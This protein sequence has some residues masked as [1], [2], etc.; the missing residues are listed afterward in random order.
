MSKLPSTLTESDIQAYV[1]G[2]LDAA[3]VSLV[4]AFLAETPAEA[5][6]V[7]Q[8][9]EIN[10]LL[11]VRHRQVMLEPSLALVTAKQPLQKKFIRGYLARAAAVGWLLIGGVVG[12]T[13]QS[14][15]L[16]VAQTPNTLVK[17][18]AFAH[19]VYVPEVVHP[20]E[21]SAQ[22][23]PHLVAWLSRR[24]KKELQVPK[25]AEFG[26]HLVG[27]RLLPDEG[28]AAA[29]FMY[30][31]ENGKR[32]TLYV[33]SDHEKNTDTSFRYSLEGDVSV[34]Y[35]IDGEFGYA[36]SGELQKSELLTLSTAVYQQLVNE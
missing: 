5:Q 29:Q 23:E 32:L 17:Q 11:R 24:L 30:E 21:V 25:L 10:R 12:W 26:Y 20:V 27:G 2:Q 8:L 35:W 18:A 4:E 13:L 9:R 31:N 22:Q 15:S 19:V 1:D 34:F 28:K 36:L 14:G 33:K 6:R 3:K 16:Q 7:D